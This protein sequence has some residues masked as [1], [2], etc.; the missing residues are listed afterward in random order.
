MVLVRF[1]GFSVEFYNDNV[2]Y[3]I[4]GFL[5]STTKVD[6]MTLQVSRGKFSWICMKVDL[7]KPLVGKV[8]IWDHMQQVVYKGLHLM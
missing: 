1:P 8:Q 5:G 3:H 4:G 2:L 7:N 6:L